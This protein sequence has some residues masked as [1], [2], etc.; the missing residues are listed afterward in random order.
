MVS[1]MLKG[2]V[3]MVIWEGS[4]G[5]GDDDNANDEGGG[6]SGDGNDGCTVSVALIQMAYVCYLSLSTVIQP[7][8]E[9]YHLVG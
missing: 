7:V 9:L 4:N 2:T 6:S 5:G 1:A 3:M 8:L